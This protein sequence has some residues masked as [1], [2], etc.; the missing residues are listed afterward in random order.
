MRDKSR[1]STLYFWLCFL[2]LLFFPL[3]FPKVRLLYF[4]PYIVVSLYQYSLKATLVRATCVG[5]LFD[6]FSS[7][8]RFGTTPW[9]YCLSTLLL[10]SQKHNFFEDKISTL[11]LMSLLFSLFSSFFSLLFAFFFDHFTFFSLK[12]VCTDWF[13]MALLDSAYALVLSLSFQLTVKVSKMISN[14]SVR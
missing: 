14:D 12:W 4:A 5:V 1:K 3:F 2:A 7:S 6:L 9:N 11:S 10:Y 8:V 13:G